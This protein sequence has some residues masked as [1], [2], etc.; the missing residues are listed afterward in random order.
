MSG[1]DTRGGVRLSVETVDATINN[2]LQSNYRAIG[3]VLET[4]GGAGGA[5]KAC[6]LTFSGDLKLQ[7]VCSVCLIICE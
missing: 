2:V 6:K 3:W 7:R 5:K 1:K 4:P